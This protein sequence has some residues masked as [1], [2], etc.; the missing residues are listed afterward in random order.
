V[1]EKIRKAIGEHRLLS[2][3][4][5]AAAAAN[6]LSWLPT[7]NDDPTLLSAAWVGVLGIVYLGRWGTHVV[8]YAIRD[9]TPQLRRLVAVEFFV[10]LG[11]ELATLYVLC[12]GSAALL[13]LLC[14]ILLLVVGLL[15]S[16]VADALDETPKL[17]AS[18]EVEKS[19]IGQKLAWVFMR[20]GL[21]DLVGVLGDVFPGRRVSALVMGMLVS[22][23]LAVLVNISAGFSETSR[24][25][26]DAF[27]HSAGKQGGSHT[28]AEKPPKA[29]EHKSARQQTRAGGADG[30]GQEQPPAENQVPP[31]LPTYENLCGPEPTG[32]PAP[33][34]QASALRGVFIAVGQPASGCAGTPQPV[35]TRSG[36]WTMTG[37]CKGETRSL[38]VAAPD[39]Q[40]ALLIGTQ[41]T[42]IG[43]ELAHAR[44]L[45]SVSA[46]VPVRSG[47]AYIL[48]T[49]RGREVLVRRF[50]STNDS[51][52]AETC[53]QVTAE[54]PLYVEMPGRLAQLWI[55][56]AKT[57]FTWP[58]EKVAGPTSTYEFMS[59]TT[60]RKLVATGRCESDSC[61][62]QLVTGVSVSTTEAVTP[63]NLKAMNR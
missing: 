29:K 46:R 22:L 15:A 4:L 8:Y 9:S 38:A 20:L 19:P 45:I 34:P 41:P 55:G 28:T 5:A 11:W 7:T 33:Q 43:L 21:E 40:G 17:T 32:A 2:A 39:G 56:L 24:V 23:A 18:A 59:D 30:N 12:V 58:R 49:T 57:R 25:L 26:R 10:A 13:L 6:S 1:I 62:V 48:R 3:A 63:A 51:G 50:S 14:V 61:F 42:R 54:A 36:T 27:P 60:P 52:G 47:D 53:E 35:T 16:E 31:A 37:Y 44:S